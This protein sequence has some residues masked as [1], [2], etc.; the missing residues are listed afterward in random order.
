VIDTTKPR[1]GVIGVGGKGWRHLESLQGQHVAALCDV[2]SRCLERAHAAYPD[3][4]VFKDYRALLSA[5]IDA[6]IIAAPDHVHAS[7]CI[8]AL[9]QGF[10]VYCEKPLVAT[11][12]EA[13]LVAEKVRSAAVCTQMGNQ[14][15]TDPHYQDAVTLARTGALGEVYEILCWTSLAWTGNPR[16]DLGLSPP[17]YLDWD[18]WLGPLSPRP[19]NPSVHPFHWR[20]WWNFGTG[21]FGDLGC[22]LLD[23]AFSVLRLSAPLEVEA[24]GEGE[25]HEVAPLASRL[26]YKFERTNRGTPVQVTVYQ[27]AQKPP[28][29]LL[30]CSAPPD[31]G[32]MLVGSRAR[33]LLCF[34][35][36]C[37]IQTNGCDS[38]EK[39]G[40]MADGLGSRR[41]LQE[42]LDCCRTGATPSASFPYALELT[43]LVLLGTAAL[44]KGKK[45]RW[46]GS[47][48]PAE[49]SEATERTYRPGWGL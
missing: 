28:K 4:A 46:D 42:W 36:G 24:T 33:L 21:S 38:W 19:Y 18:L 30:R 7:A 12:S 49:L 23:P 43:S 20:G 47:G 26:T 9:N 22:H 17:D 27:G 14:T 48:I 5:D 32:V 41:H 44:R 6:V 3:A 39:A 13:A 16:F 2:D 34:H 8:L 25:S 29:H 35:G 11:L 45:T 40:R 37:F 10:H 31:H 15:H 1:I